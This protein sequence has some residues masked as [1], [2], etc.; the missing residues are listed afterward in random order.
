M[1]RVSEALDRRALL[2]AAWDDAYDP[3]SSY[4]T[5]RG[6]RLRVAGDGLS[7]FSRS[8]ATGRW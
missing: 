1:L 5:S 6:S 7:R 3:R 8:E 2:E 4:G